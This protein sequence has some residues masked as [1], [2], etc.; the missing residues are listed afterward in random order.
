MN[1]KKQPTVIST[2]CGCGGS[3]LGYKLA[4]YKELLAIDFNENSIETF[5]QNFPEVPIWFK[6]LTKINGKDIL[7][8]C[9]IS[10]G[11]LD[12]LDGSPP[13][14][15][16]SIAGK[17]N[18]NDSRND[19]FK[20]FVRLIKELEP[21]IF[22]MENVTGMIKGTMKGKFKEIIII[23]KNLN[24]NVQCK[25]L[26]SQYFNVPQAR[27][28]LF[29]I[30]IRK[31]LNKNPVFPKPNN[32]LLTVQEVWKDLIISKIEKEEALIK[33]KRQYQLFLETKEGE[34]HKKH[35]SFAKISRHKPSRT[36]TKTIGLYHYNEPRLLVESELKRI[37]SFPDDFQFIGSLKSKYARMGNAVMPN[38]MKAIAETIKREILNYE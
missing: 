11:D 6:D 34:A 12:I 21:K 9:N 22:V 37:C 29:F 18:V 24:Y 14:Q 36:L 4:G 28:R 27:E 10:K 7:D 25:L 3:S 38:Q 23:L 35:F 1:G 33:S 2:F 31:D 26:N 19:L 32:N 20:D 16:F 13:C 17:R 5:K 8:F 15:G 30:G